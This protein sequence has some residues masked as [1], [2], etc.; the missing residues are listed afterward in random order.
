MTFW[1]CFGTHLFNFLYFTLEN[2]KKLFFKFCLNLTKSQIINI[3]KEH[4][5]VFYECKLIKGITGN[6]E[7]ILELAEKIKNSDNKI[8]YSLPYNPSLN[9]IENLFSQLKSHK[10]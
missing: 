9:P 2:L 8:I 10:K 6:G 5:L 4:D 7:F 3:K 1:T